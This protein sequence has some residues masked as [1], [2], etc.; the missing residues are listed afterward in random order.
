MKD[1]KKLLSLV[2][3]VWNEEDATPIFMEAV[4][5][6]L[7]RLEIKKEIIFID[8]GSSDNTLE[9]LLTLQQKYPIIRL[10]SLS[11]NFGKEAALTAGLDFAKGDAVIIMDVDLQ[12]PPDLIPQLLEK[13]QEGLKVVLAVRSSRNEDS[14]LKKG[15]ANFFY[16]IFNRISNT[17]I[18]PNA[19][20]FRLMDRVVLEEVKRLPEK[21]R[22]MK[23]LLSWPGFPTGLVEYARP[24]RS[25]GHSKWGT[26]KLLSFA[27]DG[28]MSFSNFLLIVWSQI[29]AMFSLGAISYG[30]FLIVRT[31][32]YGKDVPGYSSLMVVVLFLGGLQLLSFGI[33]G[34][35]IAILLDEVKGRPIY[36]VKDIY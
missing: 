18:I 31:L 30:I 33:L 21:R 23:G 24:A 16:R 1:Y 11:R 27:F 17:K 12:D 13:W 10:I 35:Y 32:L 15:A 3:P 22:F 34:R 28:I 14:I 29:G 6:V 9:V 26:F 4:L 7:N 25:A 8:D 5:P 36:V 20:D 19:G 2:V